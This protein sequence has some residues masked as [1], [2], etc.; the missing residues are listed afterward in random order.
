MSNKRNYLTDEKE[1]SFEFGSNL[2]ENA[3]LS[4]IF[5]ELTRRLKSKYEI[6]RGVFIMRSR[7]DAKFSAIS[8]WNEDKIRNNISINVSMEPSLVE[9]VAENG[10]VFSECSTCEF[11]GNFF[12]RNLIIGSDSQSY[13]LQPLKHEG[14]VVGM[15]GYG[16]VC[17][18][19]F[20]TIDEGALDKFA[21]TFGEIIG[22]RN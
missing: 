1:L 21:E 10:V 12:E 22:N 8:T 5:M 16:S 4:D 13:V 3:N 11:S 9:K 17:S 14:K 2:P 20:S 15:L 6:N 18:T 7:T 19:A